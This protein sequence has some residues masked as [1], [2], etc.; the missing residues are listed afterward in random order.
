MNK[1]TVALLIFIGA[2]VVKAETLDRVVAVVN[3]DIITASDV[4]NFEKKLRSGGMVDDLFGFD[5]Q[6][7]VKDRT[8]VVEQLISEKLIDSE[9]KRRGLGAT[10]EEVEQEVNKISSRNGI[11]RK[12]LR[13]ALKEQ[14]MSFADYQDFVRKRIERQKVIQQA[15]T[16]RI[17]I[18]DEEVASYYLSQRKGAPA[19]EAYEYTLAHILLVPGKDGVAVEEA[20]ARDLMKRVAAGE[21]FDALAAKYSEDPSFSPGGLLGTFKTGEFLRELETAASKAG[22]GELAGPVRTSAGVHILK[23]LNKV[24]IHDPELE[25]NK[26]KIRDF[27]Y[28]RAFKRQFSFWL[29]QKK[30]ESFVRLNK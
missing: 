1:L 10:I 21:S 28:Q 5:P 6:E 18:S 17:K 24:P 4:D 29:D 22:Q 7:L 25:K 9:V 3:E 13:Q 11:S 2:S 8:K 15:V 26:E 27:L 19:R 12:Q 20:K 23:I 14:G 30:R 16:S